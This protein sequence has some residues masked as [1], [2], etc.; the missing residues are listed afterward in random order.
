MKIDQRKSGRFDV[1]VLFCDIRGFT[2]LFDNRDPEEALA[3]ANSVLGELG[4]VVEACSGEIDKFTGDGFLAYFGLNSETTVNHAEEA[5]WCAIRLR[6]A[7]MN[8]NS[9]RYGFDQTVVSIGMGIHSGLVAAGTISTINKKEF[10]I[11]GSTV[12]LAS[13]IE[14]LTK[15]FGVDCLISEETAKRV[16]EKFVL[17]Q[18]PPQRLRGVSEVATTN[19]L[20]PLN[21]WP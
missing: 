19:W 16:Q 15:F 5:C 7:L 12:N 4:A 9:T 2:A 17:Q 18:M 1:T 8:I 20:S 10:T 14:A 13:R 11:L 3:F 21:L 6:S